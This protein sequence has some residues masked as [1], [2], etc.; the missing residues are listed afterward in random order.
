MFKKKMN[1]ENRQENQTFCHLVAST[2]GVIRTEDHYGAGL[3]GAG[4][5]Y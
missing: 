4:T 2:L 3:V 1:R 5:A